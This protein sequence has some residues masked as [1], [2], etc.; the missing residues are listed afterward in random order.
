MDAPWIVQQPD[1]ITPTSAP[2]PTPCLTLTV[3]L[4]EW[5]GLV[6][7][8]PPTDAAAAAAAAAAAGAG[9]GAVAMATTQARTTGAIAAEA[10]GVVANG[11]SSGALRAHHYAGRYIPFPPRP[12]PP[13]RQPLSAMPQPIAGGATP[14]A[15]DASSSFSSSSSAVA[16]AADDDGGGGGGGNNTGNNDDNS[17]A[18]ATQAPLASSELAPV[19]SWRC[20]S[21]WRSAEW[22]QWR[23]R[24]TLLPALDQALERENAKASRGAYGG[25]DPDNS[26]DTGGPGRCVII[27]SRS[28]DHCPFV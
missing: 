23:I 19:P 5:A 22:W 28:C 17:N 7:A 26:E 13:P 6:A 9:A 2:A 20:P 16:S 24:E 4:D 27:T 14:T 25:S 15:A 1:G 3:P 18:D 8:L 10:G 11:I 21:T 12:A